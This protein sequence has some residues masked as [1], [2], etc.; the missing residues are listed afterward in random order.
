MSLSELR[1]LNGSSS[2]E[3]NH[4]S[5]ASTTLHNDDNEDHDKVCMELMPIR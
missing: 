4:S 5:S 1:L 3:S 2:N